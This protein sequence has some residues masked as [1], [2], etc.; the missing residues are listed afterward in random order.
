MP[1]H[2]RPTAHPKHRSPP[3]LPSS[4]TPLPGQR[5]HHVLRA[6]NITH[7]EPVTPLTPWGA[8]GAVSSLVPLFI[9]YPALVP[10]CMRCLPVLTGE[11]CCSCWHCPCSGQLLGGWSSGGAV[12]PGG[13]DGCAGT[14]D[15]GTGMWEG[16]GDRTQDTQ[17]GV[18][19]RGLFKPATF[20]VIGPFLRSFS[21][22]LTF[23]H[24][25]DF[26]PFVPREVNFQPIGS[27]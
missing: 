18:A 22:G 6:M 13:S 1:S 4:R 3:C 2:P 27:F 25:N 8:V 11:P 24:F 5:R 17:G 23:E 10:P 12:G 19:W 21:L 7:D 20:A 9:Y 16:L 15:G 26:S 14:W